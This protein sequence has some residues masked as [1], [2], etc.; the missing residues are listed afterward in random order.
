MALRYSQG[1]LTGNGCPEDRISLHHQTGPAIA[2]RGRVA[3]LAALL[4]G[5]EDADEAASLAV[6]FSSTVEAGGQLFAAGRS[7]SMARLAAAVERDGKFRVAD[8]KKRRGFG[9]LIARRAG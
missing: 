9:L 3:L 7:T 5:N 4:R 2:G 8:R 6:A 1:N